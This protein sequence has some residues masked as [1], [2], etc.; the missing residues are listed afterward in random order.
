M[1]TTEHKLEFPSILFK[2][3]TDKGSN[4]KPELD[5]YKALPLGASILLGSGLIGRQGYKYVKKR[6]GSKK[7]GKR[8]GKRSFGKKRRSK[9]KK[10][11]KRRRSR[12]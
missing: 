8:F 1:T 3:Y 6:K 10:G 4:E 9:A 12:C 11:G 5:L 2:S 7:F